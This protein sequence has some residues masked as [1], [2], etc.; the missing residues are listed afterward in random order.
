[1]LA[2]ILLLL[3]FQP[4]DATRVKDIAFVEGVR[5]NQLVGYG[6]VVGLNGS[7]DKT[8]TIFTIRSL[9]N[10][11]SHMGV[12]TFADSV[13]VKNVAA[14]MLTANLPPFG[15]A[16]TRMDVVVSSLGDAASLQ[17]GSLIRTSLKGPDGA[18]YAVAQGTVTVGGLSV[19]SES[20][21]SVQ[22]NHPTVGRV[23][24]GAIIERE[25]PFEFNDQKDIH[26]T[27]HEPD[28]TTVIRLQEVINQHFG[29]EIA[30]ALDPGT[31]RVQVP[32]RY[33]SN[34]VA[35]VADLETL[36]VEPDVAAR[37]V[38]NERTGTIVIGSNVRVSTIA[39]SHGNLTI[40][41]KESKQVSQ[42]LPFSGGETTV[43]AE[44]EIT[45]EEEKGEI[46]VLESGVSIGDLVKALNAIGASPR[47]LIIIFEAVKAAGAL[48]AK[49][50]II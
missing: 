15:R 46:I 14:V 32:S 37:V 31:L 29:G 8:G 27:L 9:K 33:E 5:D 12:T 45:T 18:V 40:Q 7:G 10:L 4:A 49:L 3:S 25:V 48:Q 11:L 34:V 44:S 1:M 16:G 6:L 42:P 26:V 20:G 2:P 19:S 22:K 41:I 21:S 24:N 35:L 28:F 38:L 47:D 23:I 17:G 36:E 43:V 39:I 30:E 50:E 13:K